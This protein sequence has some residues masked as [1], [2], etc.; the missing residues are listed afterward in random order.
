MEVKIA[1]TLGFCF[2]VKHAIDL[3][4]KNLVEEKKDLYCMGSL[5]HNKQV[6]DRLGETGMKVVEKLDQVPEKTAA[7]ATPTVLIRSHGSR[8]ELLQ[9]VHDR[10]LNMTDATCTLVKK[11]Q[12]FVKK[13]HEE[14]YKV[15]LIGDENHP[16]VKGVIGYAPDVIVIDEEEE[17]EKL[18]KSGKIGIISQTT[19]SAEKFGRMVGK[20]AATRR[21][22]QEIKIINTICFETAKRQ[23]AAEQL[24]DEVDVMF[25][26]GSK[27]SA[28][29]TEL[30]NLCKRKGLETHHL[31]NWREFAHPM[32]HDK[33]IAGVTAGASTPD[34]IIQEFVENLRKL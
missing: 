2:G 7:G 20:I 3:A 26:V 16:E 21:N 12:E 30:A 15:V 1:E 10:G 34:W 9:A 32:I 17:I 19:H 22:Y 24:C 4:Q 14:G 6:V 8:P 27:T 29:T 25:V 31:Q 13:L 18:P 33:T 11:A 23:E 28:N 5:I